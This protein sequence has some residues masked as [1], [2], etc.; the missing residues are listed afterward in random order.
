MNVPVLNLLIGIT[1]YVAALMV[2]TIAAI[3]NRNRACLFGL[4]PV[5]LL[6]LSNLFGPT[7]LLRYFLYLVY[8]LPFFLWFGFKGKGSCNPPAKVDEL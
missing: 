5:L 3:K 6:A 2:A 7:M 4:V 8:G 1:L